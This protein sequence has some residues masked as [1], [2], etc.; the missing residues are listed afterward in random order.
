MSAPSPTGKP[1]Q[2]LSDGLAAAGIIRRD[3][4][5]RTLR[6]VWP[7]VLTGLARISQ[8][9]ADVAMVGIALGPAAVAG[10][11]FANAYWQFG[12]V[13]SLGLSGGTVS[14]VSRSFGAD[15]EAGI[16][17]TILTSCLFGLL[18]AVPVAAAFWLGSG[19]LVGLLGSGTRSLA[20]G[21][22]Y[23]RVMAV[24]VGFAFLNKVASR[25]LI[26]VGEA[27][28]PMLLRGGG[29]LV[30]LGLNLVFIFGLGLGIA[31]AALGTV[32]SLGLVTAAFAWGFV[33]GRLP[34]VG[35]FPVR[36]S[37]RTRP[38]WSDL[39]ELAEIAT[40]LAGRRVV[41]VLAVF[42]LLSVAATFGPAVV[43][44]FEVS[45]RV[46]SLSN[47]PN[48][49]F[50]LATSSLVGRKLGRG[51]EESA[52]AYAREIL[53]LSTVV[54]VLT[55]TLVFAFAEPIAGLFADSPGAMSW[56]VPFVRVA[57]VS[58]IGMGI[59]GTVTGVL[60]SS[61]DARWPFYGKLVYALVL[62]VAVLGVDQFGVTVLY[63][64]LLAE[65][66]IPAGVSLYRF[67]TDRWLAVS[68]GYRPT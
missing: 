2:W 26:G 9:V 34:L 23:L 38:D 46:R 21:A 47:A 41:P 40:P 45:R 64:A 12:N 6:L 20:F 39:R 51:D 44:A 56:T 22:T 60:R 49:G 10:L 32:V 42:P 15:D 13:L 3:R 68:R 29:A 65:T 37:G 50:S 57:A 53:G 27:Q 67:T 19:R 1:L 35:A 16:E 52:R 33:G 14:G 62:P 54:Y 4:A 36:I 43:A 58:L 48:W 63:A 17:R 24:G 7:R 59:D 55:A 28:I 61:G 18:L 25:T 5:E 66:T 8:R 30:N 31:G 11:A